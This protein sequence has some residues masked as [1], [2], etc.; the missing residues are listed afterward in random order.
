MVVLTP[1]SGILSHIMEMI[2]LPSEMK[3]NFES[4]RNPSEICSY[5]TLKWAF[6][7]RNLKAIKR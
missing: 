6:D 5:F 3:V 4:R 1:K 7:K 2:P